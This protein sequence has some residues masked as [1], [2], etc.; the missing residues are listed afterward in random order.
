MAEVVAR[1]CELGELLAESER[2]HALALV[3]RVRRTMRRRASS[4]ALASLACALVWGG[5]LGVPPERAAVASL[6][7]TR[8]R[9][10]TAC[11]ELMAIGAAEG[12]GSA[13]V[14]LARR[15]V[16]R[17]V[18]RA[19]ELPVIAER[20]V[21][22]VLAGALVRELV[23]WRARAGV[24]PRARRRPARAA[25]VVVISADASV[26]DALAIHVERAGARASTASAIAD[27]HVLLDAL[28]VDAIVCGD[29]ALHD[30][31]AS[32][33]AMRDGAPPI[34][35]VRARELDAVRDAMIIAQ[36]V[37][38]SGEG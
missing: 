10:D 18:V 8:A 31:L 13:A 17:A 24:R 11:V 33:C 1:A 26:R 4:D 37:R 16:A 32:G 23:W 28:F 3:E 27:V 38:T 22:T 35:A 7:A 34:V 14:S 21:D 19:L 25:H 30:A 2:V 12:A 9:I 20:R 15:S 6:R 5:Q 36:M 29:D